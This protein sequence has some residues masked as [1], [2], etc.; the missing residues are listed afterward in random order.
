MVFMI[1]NPGGGLGGWILGTR[2]QGIVEVR[3]ARA[4][5]PVS[6]NYG[7]QEPKHSGDS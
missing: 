4:L 5:L 7:G 1:V 2:E 3:G 6:S